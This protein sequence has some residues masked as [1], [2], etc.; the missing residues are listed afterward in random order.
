MSSDQYA[1]TTGS[2]PLDAPGADRR[3]DQQQHQHQHQHR[4]SPVAA[5]PGGYGVGGRHPAHAHVQYPAAGMNTAPQRRRLSNAPSDGTT[6]GRSYVGPAPA[7]RTAAVHPDHDA[8]S[9]DEIESL[10][11]DMSSDLWALQRQRMRREQLNNN[12]QRPPGSTTESPSS[13]LTQDTS[14]VAKGKAVALSHYQKPAGLALH[15]QEIS[16][17]PPLAPHL[18]ELAG[19]SEWPAYA[20]ASG[21]IELTVPPSPHGYSAYVYPATGSPPQPYAQ[22]T[23]AHQP[24][25]AHHHFQAPP[26]PQQHHAQTTQAYSA[27]VA[28]AA[29]YAAQAPAPAYVHGRQLTTAPPLPPIVDATSASRDYSVPPGYSIDAPHYIPK[30][31]PTAGGYP[32]ATT[33]V[34]NS[35]RY[36]SASVQSNDQV[37]VSLTDASGYSQQ[38]LRPQHATNPFATAIAAAAAISNVYTGGSSASTDHH[39]R[40]L[41]E[42]FGTY[43]TQHQLRYP[44]QQQQ[45]QQVQQQSP[46]PPP[47]VNAHSPL[48]RAAGSPP[49]EQ[50]RLHAHAVVA[51][52]GQPPAAYSTGVNSVARAAD[53]VTD[54]GS[55]PA[56]YAYTSRAQQQHHQPLPVAAARVSP[57]MQEMQEHHSTLADPTTLAA[58]GR[59]SPSAPY[60]ALSG[61]MAA[62]N[63]GAKVPS[64]IAIQSLLNSP[65]EDTF[66]GMADD[67]D[68]CGSAESGSD[69]AAIHQHI[70]KENARFRQHSSASG[71]LPIPPHIAPSAP[72]AHHH[73]S[74]PNSRS[75]YHSAGYSVWHGRAETVNLDF[76]TAQQSLSS[77]DDPAAAGLGLSMANENQRL[78]PAY[79]P[80]APLPTI[81]ASFTY[82]TNAAATAFA[83]STIA[84]LPPP[85]QADDYQY[86]YYKPDNKR[87]SKPISVLVQVSDGSREGSVTGNDDDHSDEAPAFSPP[88]S[89]VRL[90]SEVQEP[91]SPHLP[92]SIVGDVEDDMLSG[93]AIVKIPLGRKGTNESLDNVLEYYR[94]HSSETLDKRASSSELVPPVSEAEAQQQQQQLESSLDEDALFALA[95]HGMSHPAN[96]VS[97]ADLNATRSDSLFDAG[98]QSPLSLTGGSHMAAAAATEST[99][100]A[101][102]QRRQHQQQQHYDGWPESRYSSLGTITMPAESSVLGTR[103]HTREQTPMADS[104]PRASSYDSPP[105][106]PP[107]ELHDNEQL[108]SARHWHID[109]GDS[110][111][112][113]MD[114]YAPH[115]A[116]NPWQQRQAPS[117]YHH[118]DV[119]D[120]LE[121]LPEPETLELPP[122][123]AVE[124]SLRGADDIDDDGD[125]VVQ[126]EMIDGISEL[127]DM[128]DMSTTHDSDYGYSNSNSS[129]DSFGEPI[130]HETGIL[131]KSLGPQVQNIAALTDMSESVSRLTDDFSRAALAPVMVI[132]QLSTQHGPQTSMHSYFS[133]VAP[134]PGTI[135]DQRLSVLASNPPDGAVSGAAQRLTELGVDR[136]MLPDSYSSLAQEMD[137]GSAEAL[138]SGRTNAST[139]TTSTSPEEHV[140]ITAVAADTGNRAHLVHGPVAAVSATGTSTA[141]TAASATTDIVQAAA[142]A[143][144]TANNMPLEIMELAGELEISLAREQEDYYSDNVSQANLDPM[145]LQNLGKAVHQQCLLQR[146]HVQRRKSNMHLGLAGG[147]NSSSDEHGVVLAADLPYDD[148]EL[149]L[150]AMLVEVS[151]YFAQSGLNQV[152]PFSA[153]WVD[154]LTRHPDRPFPWRKDPEDDDENN[155]DSS[156][157]AGGGGHDGGDGD[158]DSDSHSDVSSF[159]EEPPALSRPLP[160]EDV[161]SKATIPMS[162]RR[163]VLV[164]DFVSQEKR[165]GINAHWQYYSVINQ[166]TAVAS[167]IHR[168][169]VVEEADADHSFVAHQLAAL[170][171]FL[172][173]DFKKFKPGI[174]SIFETIKQSLCIKS[175]PAAGKPGLECASEGEVDDAAGGVRPIGPQ[176]KVLDA[177]CVSVLREM[178]ASIIAEA[179]Y[180][181]SKVAATG[182]KEHPPPNTPTAGIRAAKQ[183][184]AAV[185]AQTQTQQTVVDGPLVREASYAI[186][187]L[188]GLPTQPIVRYLAKEMRAVN[189]ERRR[190]GLAHNLSRNNSMGHMR[191]HHHQ[192]PYQ[193]QPPLPPLPPMP[194]PAVPQAVPHNNAYHSGSSA[195][196]TNHAPGAAVHDG[197]AF[198]HN[199]VRRNN[200]HWQ[201][202]MLKQDAVAAAATV[203][204]PILSADE[205]A[206][207]QQTPMP[208]DLS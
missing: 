167:G 138:H 187:T 132:H 153:K 95:D 18:P 177:K 166:I 94:T 115:V 69:T 41:P 161:L 122:T 3:S 159:G 74:S 55:T 186:S 83:A 6:E 46:P 31:W 98:F 72:T 1:Y 4:Y 150:K 170:Y 123:T 32:T 176:P 130:E 151:Q 127:S 67:A 20:D 54:M 24:H 136:D 71:Q 206:M 146:Q 14:P 50:K 40:P 155:R 145:I 117:M 133:R 181:T 85:N 147:G 66:A 119:Y 96:M 113:D 9:E 199:R 47:M 87:D 135:N 154:W 5:V 19:Q 58:F 142:A 152:F 124:T 131:A 79:L 48:H 183:A 88:D 28:A 139:L 107:M 26:P 27:A 157:N 121:Q 134:P 208:A 175:T 158:D 112:A 179:L 200:S 64:A 148:Y 82:A 34:D 52:T 163:P 22:A 35:G 128:L 108:L 193:T 168:R 90:P 73:N 207:V 38:Q 202:P 143:A 45:Q 2:P 205:D 51:E 7:R 8:T 13:P 77:T 63:A 165:R 16:P 76:A 44:R 30:L 141:P 101:P 169:L 203:L 36:E 56:Y 185:A 92:E 25:Y 68:S 114:M 125:S 43:P 116:P 39:V 178:M 62:I 29:A 190:R 144:T 23:Y 60:P 89:N 156:N 65:L 195:S 100:S 10:K 53:H 164:K 174:E 81:A 192:F 99:S 75:S 59:L 37:S 57:P 149:A 15:R 198:E 11:R 191:H 106:Q 17:P 49:M 103:P 172:G 182:V 184:A 160:P 189:G 196:S 12:R 97:K 194:A 21:P 129:T 70:A 33:N 171:Q 61:P 104:S 204:Q 140:P 126:M 93:D 102:V 180:S 118:N 197:L 173:G 162:M 84:S 105:S 111:I 78:H 137:S 86:R 120:A 110:Y 80:N 201:T 188:K 109:V 91:S 42:Q